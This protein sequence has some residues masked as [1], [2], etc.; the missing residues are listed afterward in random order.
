MAEGLHRT[1]TILACLKEVGGLVLSDRQTGKSTALA[2][3][4]AE[5]PEEYVIVTHNERMIQMYAE[6]ATQ[7]GADPSSA[8]K[9]RVLVGRQNLIVG[10]GKNPIIRV[11]IDEI[12]MNKYDGEH[13]AAV[14]TYQMATVIN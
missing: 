14:G 11:F 6:L 9:I 8:K 3:L 12:F 4:A 2:L 5:N 1:Q 10:R 13:Y 7:N